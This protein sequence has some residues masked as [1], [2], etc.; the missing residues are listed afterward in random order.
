MDP[1]A[2]CMLA[3]AAALLMPP[4]CATSN[5]VAS[6]PNM[7]P[8]NKV[9]ILNDKGQETGFKLVNK[10]FTIKAVRIDDKVETPLKSR[11][12]EIYFYE[13]ATKKYVKVKSGTTDNKGQY[14]YTPTKVGKYKIEC[15]S[16]APILEI[17]K[18]Y[19]K[20]SDFGAV[21]GDGTCENTKL[22]TI[23]NCPA[24]CAVCGDFI[25]TEA[26]ED[27]QSCPD[28][29][30]ICGDEVC[31]DEEIGASEIYCPEDCLKC[32]D[33]VCRRDYNETCPADCGSD[34]KSAGSSMPE[35]WWMVIGGALVI[36]A[37]AFEARGR[38]RR[39]GGELD[40]ATAKW[41]SFKEGK[42]RG[43]SREE[44]EKPK[45]AAPK[46]SKDDSEV[47]EII[48]ELVDSGVSDK[49]IKGKLQEFG[50]SEEE[51]ERLVEKVKK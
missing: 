49:R 16:K 34:T 31:D 19:D 5:C 12:V 47:Q 48:Q 43:W 20:P 37:I 35:Y 21:C 25:C 38:F 3:L 26:V 8:Y 15:A 17:M 44:G 7:G 14:S 29:C 33:G 22:E 11:P 36:G 18:V 9:T 24:D 1:K 10:T 45:K 2:L 32:G 50:L 28:D 4:A 6:Q 40:E 46:S 39:G 13:T 41:R 30:V 27:K 42:D 51:A 23:D